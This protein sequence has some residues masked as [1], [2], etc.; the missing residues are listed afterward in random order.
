MNNEQKPRVWTPI[1]KI[2]LA[3]G[4]SD[5]PNITSYSGMG[6][7]NMGDT[8]EQLHFKPYRNGKSAIQPNDSSSSELKIIFN[9]SNFN[10]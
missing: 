2:A 1:D 6:H 8:E 4:T 10:L 5:S 7:T 9:I 3:T